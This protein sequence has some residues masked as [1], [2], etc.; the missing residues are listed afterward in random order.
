MPGF[1]ALPVLLGWALL[2]CGSSA[3][4][5]PEPDLSLDERIAAI[6]QDLSGN[7]GVYVRHVESGDA[8]EHQADQ[9]WY[10][11]STVK[12]PVAVAVLQLVEE[13]DLSLD[14]TLTLQAS[15]WVDGAGEL[16][17]HSPGTEYTLRELVVLSLTQSDS[18]ATDMLIRLIGQ[19][20]LNRRVGGGMTSEGFYT[21]TPILQVRYDAYGEIHPDVNELS[22]Q[23]FVRL[24]QVPLG[25]ERYDAFLDKLPNPSP[26]PELDGIFVAFERYYGR[27]LNSA[28]LTAFGELLAR[29]NSGDLLTSHHTE[30]LLE[31]MSDI[32]TG[33]ERIV[34]GLPGDVTFAHK[35]GTQVARACN[36]GIAEPQTPRATVIVACAERYE[37]LTEA[38]AAFRRVGEAVVDAGVLD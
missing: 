29:L 31:T 11:A 25:P 36:V 34:A 2:A 33:A 28:R 6:D 7:L 1:H 15:D 5:D 18:T 37:A 14:D 8:W 13:G 4:E 26:E 38:E 22:N 21:I 35:T 19:D 20:E 17:Y 23:D 12:V 30:W 32:D 27:Q 9:A 10:Q 16:L 24:N 3:G